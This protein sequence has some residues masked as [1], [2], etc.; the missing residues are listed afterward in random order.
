[1]DHDVLAA[2]VGTLEMRLASLQSRCAAVQTRLD[3]ERSR[4][5]S[6]STRSSNGQAH[7][8]VPDE[9]EEVES[10]IFPT[11]VQITLLLRSALASDRSEV[12][13]SEEEMANQVL[14]PI[15]SGF[16]SC[17]KN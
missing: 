16:S 12:P 11:L 8:A 5:A 14:L 6:E 2:K 10:P 13:A 7:N 4:S 9:E 1:M 17:K 3:A 15:T